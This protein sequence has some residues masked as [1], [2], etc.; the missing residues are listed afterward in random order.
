MLR[1]RLLVICAAALPAAPAV[2]QPWW[3]DPR[4]RRGEYERWREE[5]WRRRAAAERR[6]AWREERERRMWE[7]QRRQELRRE[8]EMRRGRP[9]GDRW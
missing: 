2:A 3:G 5:E 1:R 7:A 6:E 9:P 8:W 4:E